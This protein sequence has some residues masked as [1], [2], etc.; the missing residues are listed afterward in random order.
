MKLIH[1]FVNSQTH[2]GVQLGLPSHR[3]V[4]GPPVPGQCGPGQHGR[5]GWPQQWGFHT[6]GNNWTLHYESSITLL[7]ISVKHRLVFMLRSPAWGNICQ[8]RY[9]VEGKKYN[10]S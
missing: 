2:A 5:K 7:V 3:R 9:N 1:C 8:F 10:W 6:R 4:S